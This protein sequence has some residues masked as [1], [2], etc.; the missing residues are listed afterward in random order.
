MYVL[1]CYNSEKLTA[2]YITGEKLTLNN[3]LYLREQMFKKPCLKVKRDTF[4]KRTLP[5]SL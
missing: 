3:K 5:F 1:L 4:R 2:D